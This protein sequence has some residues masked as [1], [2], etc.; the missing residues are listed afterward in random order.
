MTSK[1][2]TLPCGLFCCN[3]CHSVL[4]DK[5][6]S[7]DKTTN[8]DIPVLYVLSSCGK[9]TMPMVL[10]LSEDSVEIFNPRHHSDT[11]FSSFRWSI[12]ARVECRPEAF[13]D[14]FHLCLLVSRSWKY[15]NHE[16][17]QSR[18]EKLFTDFNETDGWNDLLA[19]ALQAISYWDGTC[20][21]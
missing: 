20:Q 4:T 15:C 17:Q 5:K 9:Y 3:D 11:H 18:T 8:A 19:S 1:N 12:G 10:G 14:L 6:V 7:I 21:P 16:N 2:F 13:T